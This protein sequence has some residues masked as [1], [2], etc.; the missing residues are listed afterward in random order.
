MWISVISAYETANKFEEDKEAHGLEIAHGL[1]YAAGQIVAYAVNVCVG[2]EKA[3]RFF[4]RCGRIWYP[5][6]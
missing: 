1:R 2:A 3:G 4:L 5:K 6:I